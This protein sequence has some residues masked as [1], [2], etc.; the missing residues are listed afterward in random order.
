MLPPPIPDHEL[1]H[2]I[3]RGSY[4]EVWLARNVMGTYR[5]A[6]IV[7]RGT[8]DSDHP[9]EREFAGIQKFE[10]VSRSHEGL[11]QVL[12]VG[13]NEAE[14]YFYYVME[15][16]DDTVHGVTI[17][18]E[19]YQPRTL[20]GAIGHAGD[21]TLETLLDQALALAAA[22]GHLHKNGLLHRDLKPSNIIFVQ[23]R[24]KLADIGLVAD[25]GAS[26]SFVGTEGFIPPEGP[27]TPAADLYSLGKLLYEA[28]TGLD[29]MKFPEIPPAW[30]ELPRGHGWLEFHEIILKACEGQAQRR[31]RN[32]GELQADLALLQSGRSVRRL[33]VLE[34]RL[35][36]FK[37]A[38]VAAALVGVLACVGY[39]VAAREARREREHAQRV[40]RAEY[41]AR[42]QLDNALLAQARAGRRS[43]TSGASV[44]SLEALR[45][46]AGRS[47]TLELRNEAIA[48]LALPDLLPRPAQVL[49]GAPSPQSCLDTRWD[50]FVS[51]DATGR[52]AWRALKDNKELFSLPGHGAAM[53][54]I[55]FALGSADH[56][57]TRDVERTLQIWEV[58]KR[59]CC[60]TLSNFPGAAVVD[61][62]PATRQ[63]AV[64]G[65]ANQIDL[66]DLTSG[67]VE[68][69]FRLTAVPEAVT[70]SPDGK[71]LAATLN[72]GE[73]VAVL[74][75]VTGEEETRLRP[76]LPLDGAAWL[77]DGRWLATAGRDTRVQL[78]EVPS[79]I[80][81]RTLDGHHARLS[82]LA[83]HPGGQLLATASWDG[84]TSLWDIAT[85]HRWTSFPMAGTD[86][87][88][89]PD[90]RRLSF[91]SFDEQGVV[92]C[93]VFPDR[94][95]RLWSEPDPAVR[96][97]DAK[98]PWG[99][100]FSAEG[101]LLATASYDGVRLWRV[102]DARELAHLPLPMAR[103]VMFNPAKQEWVICCEQGVLR[104][105]FQTGEAMGAGTAGSVQ[106]VSATDNGY[107]RGCLSEDGGLLAYRH[108]DHVSVRPEGERGFA[109]EAP[110]MPHW[111][112]LSPDKRW[113]ATCTFGHPSLVR[114][115][116]LA[117]RAE[118]WRTNVTG[119]A[120]V[121]FSPDGHWLV[122]GG[123]EEVC[124]WDVATGRPG[125][126]F[127][128]R[129]AAT[130]QGPVAFS[131]DGRFLALAVTRTEVQLRDARTGTELA[132]LESPLPR[133]ISA[134]TFNA[135]GDQLAVATEAH[136]IQLWD[137]RALRERLAKMNL[138]WP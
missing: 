92:V 22:L 31:Y 85:G 14:G 58:P 93:D 2:L 36:Q 106:I 114:L 133:T 122:T 23:G 115:W 66:L 83:V 6:K 121:A 110:E 96:H 135:A 118:Q 82:G 32:A 43:R 60:L 18:P 105:P 33:R 19:T 3:G 90:G 78:W 4:G 1:L 54:T 102:D 53:K 38:S 87:R 20:R 24:P 116:N 73:E 27:G 104:W 112:D 21:V 120:C 126:R 64:G 99:L 95:C 13:R 84:T 25:V 127:P 9:Y 94:V 63:L 98:G 91:H 11:V 107:H 137:L 56:L 40:E 7:R 101:R 132:V 125:W 62:S 69:T 51:S 29:R 129:N 111:V 41:E 46:A 128:R 136:L 88:F 34:R 67:V 59:V 48:C 42:R 61:I 57:F 123:S 117:E 70:F 8:F 130:L 44:L 76:E 71:R 72:Q 26:R 74:N 5:A 39:F 86:L 45:Q 134:L 108:G 55:W 65:L 131:R 12:H 103:S 89:S 50:A 97:E 15:L 35:S 113:L 47:N 49:P 75:A 68:K 16:A 17:H 79:G 30:L 124:F 138:A 100:A 119:S 109:L 10:P 52:L 28:A 80:L 81:R 77:T 37:K